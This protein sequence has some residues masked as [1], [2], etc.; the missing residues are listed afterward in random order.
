MIGSFR[1]IQPQPINC[2]NRLAEAFSSPT[3]RPEAEDIETAARSR[4]G[5]GRDQIAPMIEYRHRNRI[6]VLFS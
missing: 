5:K 1:W 2:A 6:E 3:T 4:R